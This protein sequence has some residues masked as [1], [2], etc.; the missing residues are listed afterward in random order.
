VEEWE[1]PIDCF[2][3]HGTYAV[4]FKHVRSGV[5]LRCP[6][7]DGSYVVSTELNGRVSRALR[8]FHESW[9]RDFERMQ[10]RRRRELE[11]FEERQ[12]RALEAF[13]ERLLQASRNVKP[14]GAPRKKAWI[15]G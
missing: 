1:V 9:T 3:C 6:F 12:A 5:V 7:C 10:E 14:P 4:A 8:E 15:F 13:N 2:R 11:Q